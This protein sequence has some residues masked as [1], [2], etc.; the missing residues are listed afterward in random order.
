MTVDS[1]LVYKRAAG[2]GIC[3]T[4]TSDVLEKAR[5][6][7]TKITDRLETQLAWRP[8]SHWV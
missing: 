4:H 1:L 5:R 6:G 7:R 2:R 3:G 8:A